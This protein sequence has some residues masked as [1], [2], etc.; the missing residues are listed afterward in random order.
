MLP[1][2][3]RQRFRR[4]RLGTSRVFHATILSA[5]VL[6]TVYI[7]Y[8]I[9]L[10][11]T[12]EGFSTSDRGTAHISVYSPGSVDCVAAHDLGTVAPGDSGTFQLV[13]TNAGGVT[14]DV[15]E[16]TAYDLPSHL[17]VAFTKS[18]PQPGFPDRIG[19]GESITIDVRW[20]FDIGY[21]GAGGVD[22]SFSINVVTTQAW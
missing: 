20:A 11:R 21:T 13:I 10:G 16:P 3:C 6:A 7:V 12:F 22:F 18:S 14:L 19:P 1:K 4:T 8:G 5:T 9:S 15:A 2:V 17:S